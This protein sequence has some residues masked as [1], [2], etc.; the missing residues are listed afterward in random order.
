MLSNSGVPSFCICKSL[1]LCFKLME[2]DSS[3]GA[4]AVGV[5]EKPNKSENNEE[6]ITKEKALGSFGGKETF[7]RADQIDF[8]SWDIQLEKHLSKGWSRVK[9]SHAPMEEWEIDLAKLDI[10]YVIAHGTY[11]TVYRGTYDGQDV[12]GNLLSLPALV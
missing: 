2:M 4:E 11:G 3:N 1:S 9:E 6:S 5:A 10:R 7:F 12:A 8:K